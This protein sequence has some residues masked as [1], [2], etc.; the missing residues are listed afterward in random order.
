[1]QVSLLLVLYMQS[2]IITSALYYAKCPYYV[3]LYGPGA[4]PLGPPLLSQHVQREVAWVNQGKKQ[5][6]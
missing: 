1:M 4:G 2:V 6:L 5:N 3:V